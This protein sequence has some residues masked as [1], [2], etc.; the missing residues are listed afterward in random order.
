MVRNDGSPLGQPQGKN[1]LP[2][3]LLS[4]RV[5]STDVSFSPMYEESWD[6]HV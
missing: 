1:F 5:Y 2:P 3:I 4:G 6:R